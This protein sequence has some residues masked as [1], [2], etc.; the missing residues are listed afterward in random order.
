MRLLPLKPASW[1]FVYFFLITT[2]ACQKTASH[3]ST[4]TGTS[5]GPT[6]SS[7]ATV[8][9]LVHSN[10]TVF[11]WKNGVRIVLSTMP[12]AY[13]SGLALSD[14][15]VYVSGGFYNYD[16]VGGDPQ[17]PNYKAAYWK[18]GLLTILPD[19]EADVET[20]GIAVSGNDVYVAG[21]MNYDDTNIIVPYIAS[22]PPFYFAKFGRVALYWKNGV[23][24]LLP[25]G[26]LSGDFN[27]DGVSNYDD[28]ANGIFSSGNDVYVV[29]GS[30]QW[31]WGDVNSLHFT[32]YWKD[33]SPTDLVNNVTG[34]IPDSTTGINAPSARA[35][36]G[37]GSDVYVA[38][39]QTLNKTT[40]ETQ[41]LYWKNGTL[42]YLTTTPVSA[43]AYAVYVSGSDV[44]VAGS[45]QQPGGV[46]HATYWKNGV[47]VTIDSSAN[48][49]SANYITV[50][51][52]DVYTA[53]IETNNPTYFPV[54][55]KNSKMTSLGSTGFVY[56]LAVK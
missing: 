29:G 1:L 23:A 3:Q 34:V 24:S 31:Q 26:E 25:G 11:Y 50:A 14:T 48:A 16:T 19:S 39:Y 42:N 30:G 28:M 2:I 21:V 49:T 7:T 55:W 22:P 45:L 12:S 56:G 54:Y 8:Y 13:C 33:G 4:P 32:V 41:A 47:A 6:D 52:N 5:T 15:D 17:F 9:V 10:D 20:F 44:Y 36:Y 35:I 27:G 46:Q 38:G 43:Y 51:G 37:S 40:F 53:G 18:N